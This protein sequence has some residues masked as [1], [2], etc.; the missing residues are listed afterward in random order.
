VITTI[1]IAVLAFNIGFVLGA[2]WHNLHS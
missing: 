2:A 1:I